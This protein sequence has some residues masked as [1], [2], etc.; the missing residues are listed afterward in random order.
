MSTLKLSF[1]RLATLQS[2]HAN[3]QRGGM[4]RPKDAC[5]A[6]FE[7]NPSYAASDD[8]NTMSSC[9]FP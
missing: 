4:V 2:S 3:W 1:S 9:L 7:L 5:S 8:R 6:R